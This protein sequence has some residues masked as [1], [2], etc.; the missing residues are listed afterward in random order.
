MDTPPQDLAAEQSVLGAILLNNAM[1][2][3]VL[4]LIKA[5]DFYRPVN[6]MIFDAAVALFTRGEPADAITVGQE[7][8]TRK[9]FTKVGGAPALLEIIQGVPMASNAA[10]YAKVV[11]QK[12]K[13]RGMIAVGSRFIQLASEVGDDE[14][15][16]A[17]GQAEQYFREI[18]K[19][20]DETG[21]MFG[22]LAG[23]WQT[24]QNKPEDIIPTP[25]PEL[26]DYLGG[27]LRKGK[28]YVIAGRPGAGKSMGGLNIVSHIAENGLPVTVFSLEMGK[29]EVAGRLLASGAYANYGQIFRKQ[30]EKD[31]FERVSEYIDTR[32][33][34][35]LEVVDKAGVTVEQIVGHIRAKK[36]AAVFIDYCQLITASFRG[37][38]RE[39]ID[40]ITRSLK[41]C[42]SDTGTAIILASQVNRNGDGRMPT[43]ADLRESGSIENDADV[44]L[45]LHR[46]DHAAGTVKMNV[47]KNRDGKQGVIEFIWRGDLARIG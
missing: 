44:V 8:A 15:D 4:E 42:A 45:L 12:A 38:R 10:H 13:L 14:F 40:H 39:A 33:G 5:G 31:T 28:L 24:W 32:R 37:D 41:V 18:R 26:N 17:I 2:P 11:A 20:A 23:M 9:Q 22:E 21:V 19:P 35:N 43:I 30:M 34:M 46:E 27:G 36:P 29:L 47:G 16:D 3:S 1:I 25:W 6:A 7:L